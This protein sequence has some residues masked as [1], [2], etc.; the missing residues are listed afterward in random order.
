MVNILAPP[1]RLRGA[2]P[3]HSPMT[4]T[5]SI[6]TLPDWYTWP[7]GKLPQHLS[8]RS[9][10]ARLLRPSIQSESENR[11]RRTRSLHFVYRRGS[12]LNSLFHPP[13]LSAI[14]TSS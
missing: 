9:T 6:G 2:H 13:F 14:Q 11:S 10:A 12:A 7:S 1:G 4:S 3:F 8:I 5:A